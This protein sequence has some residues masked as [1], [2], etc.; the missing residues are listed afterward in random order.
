[1]EAPDKLC[2]YCGG[3]VAKDICSECGSHNNPHYKYLDPFE[4]AWQQGRL[5]RSFKYG[6]LVA[7]ALLFWFLYSTIRFLMDV[8]REWF[9]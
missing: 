7:G 4:S 5:L 2:P 6:K 8:A 9:F 3:P 1:M